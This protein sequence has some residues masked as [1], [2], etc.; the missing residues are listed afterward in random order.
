MS[1]F[2]KPLTVMLL[3]LIS[4]CLLLGAEE[5]T[6]DAPAPSRR[7]QTSR[8]WTWMPTMGLEYSTSLGFGGN[9]G[10]YLADFQNGGE[11]PRFSGIEL[12]VD[13]YHRA[14]GVTLGYS[15]KAIDW[16]VCNGVSLRAGYLHDWDRERLT[17]GER[18]YYTAVLDLTYASVT[19]RLRGLAD[20]A[21]KDQHLLVGVLLKF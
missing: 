2:L 16:M 6:D 20:T 13:V 10:A 11:S 8:D 15:Y 4:T 7:P 21:G 18:G 17:D 1:Q 14:A 3:L 12:S 5:G 9:V 19:W